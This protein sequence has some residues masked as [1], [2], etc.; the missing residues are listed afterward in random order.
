MQLQ[1]KKT[2][3]FQTPI[4]KLIKSDLEQY[5]LDGQIPAYN[6][7]EVYVVNDLHIVETT[8]LEYELS[9]VYPNPFNPTANIEIKMAFDNK[10]LLEV[11]DING[12]KVSILHEGFMQK[13]SHK[14]QW[15]AS[16]YSSGIY[17]I[18]MKSANY[19]SVQKIMLL[20]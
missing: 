10:V 6:I 9:R 16:R 11:Y 17:F 8:I 13:G 18:K 4:F 14:M 20:K 5:V 12:N 19:T 3:F 15:D 1:N 7:N 2:A